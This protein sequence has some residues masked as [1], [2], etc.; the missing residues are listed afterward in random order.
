MLEGAD[1]T[2]VVPVSGTL[3]LEDVDFLRRRFPEAMAIEPLMIRWADVGRIGERP[4]SARIEGGTPIG[5]DIRNLRVARGRYLV[6]SDVDRS[7]KVCVLGDEMARRLFGNHLAVDRS[8][9]MFGSR[10]TVVGVLEPRGSMMRFDYDRLI[11]TPLTSMHERVGMEVVNALL[12]RAADKG[13]ALGIRDQILDEMLARLHR[14]KAEDFRIFCQDELIRQHDKTLRTFR[15]LMFSVAAFS[16]LVSGVGI[17]N[18]MLVTVRERTREVGIWKAVGAA[19]NDV[20]MYFLGESVLTC[21]VGGALG[22]L[23]GIVLAAEAA[24]FVADTVAETATWAPVFRPQFFVLSFGTAAL[25]GLLSGI[26]PAYIAAR[27]EPVEALR[28]E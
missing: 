25:V 18:I 13:A 1:P 8:I 12:I 19:D 3:S 15:I 28:Y 22:V 7:E 23:L 24:G 21:M 17:M 27:L 20:L 14:R 5:A 26:F 9:A 10:W 4:F 11:I 2:A 16:L 6:P